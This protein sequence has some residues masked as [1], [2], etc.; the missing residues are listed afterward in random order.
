[1]TKIQSQIQTSIEDL[2]TCHVTSA[3]NNKHRWINFDNPTESVEIPERSTAEYD[4]YEFPKMTIE[5]LLAKRRG[6]YKEDLFSK[7]YFLH[8]KYFLYLD[9]KK[10]TPVLPL[11][12][13]KLA[14][15]FGSVQNAA[16]LLRHLV[17]LGALE[18]K[19]KTYHFGP[20][21]SRCRT[22]LINLK[23]FRAVTKYCKQNGIPPFVKI[24]KDIDVSSVPKN[25]RKLVRIGGVQIN[26]KNVN[27]AQ[28][29]KILTEKYPFIRE[30]R[31]EIRENNKK[32]DSPFFWDTCEFGFK[33]SKDRTKITNIG[34][35]VSN[36]LCN[37]TREERAEILKDL[38]ITREDDVS[39]S[40]LSFN[41][42]LNDG[43][44]RE[45]QDM[46][47]AVYDNLGL[48]TNFQYTRKMI[49]A[50]SF[51]PIFGKSE[52]DIFS[53]LD[54][55]CDHT[56]KGKLKKSVKDG[57][58][59]LQIAMDKAIGHSWGTVLFA[60]E[61]YVLF[62]IKQEMMESGLE[63]YQVYDCLYHNG[64]INLEKMLEKHFNAFYE[65]Y[66]QW[67]TGTKKDLKDQKE[68]KNQS[69][70]KVLTDSQ[71]GNINSSLHSELNCPVFD[72]NLNFNLNYNI[73]KNNSKINAFQS[74]S[75]PLYKG[76]FENIEMSGDCGAEINEKRVEVW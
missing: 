61:S 24:E 69:K 53:K 74:S 30:L 46:Y 36:S 41:K 8:E 11:S 2:Y 49:K 57:I 54:F 64:D 47:K 63:V 32:Y 45:P 6:V 44:W 71:T 26:L 10:G 52:D 68:F 39:A 75:L 66:G 4:D 70:R 19:D 58:H 50:L 37:R 35:R 42:S 40:V 31:K 56:I 1:M 21:K 43:R 25:I 5:E 27:E 72:N 9:K 33:Y 67:I 18:Y 17:N 3:E 23:I 48:E 29:S 14:R 55:G 60:V 34:F 73:I 22:F 7:M 38:N 65:K 12:T 62:K 15:Y 20:T 59:S 13:H 16:V 51:R 76:D 28:I